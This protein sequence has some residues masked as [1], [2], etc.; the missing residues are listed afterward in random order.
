MKRVCQMLCK[1][2]TTSLKFY[3]FQDSTSEP[4]M[5][6]IINYRRT[7]SYVDRYV[8]QMESIKFY[9]HEFKPCSDWEMGETDLF[10]LFLL[11]HSVL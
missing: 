6:P 1:I 4:Q 5:S 10:C 9:S 2:R 8:I 11:H 7:I 3:D